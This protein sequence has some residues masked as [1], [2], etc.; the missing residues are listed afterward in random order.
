M[1]KKITVLFCLF[2]F[3]FANLF[4]SEA[5]EGSSNNKY[6]EIYNAGSSTVDLSGYAFPNVSNAP[7][8]PGNYEYW[9]VFDDD[10]TVLIFK[11]TRYS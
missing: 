6:L 2:G 10:A 5:A 3:T 7:D 11:E 8:E 1:F 4:F 9:N